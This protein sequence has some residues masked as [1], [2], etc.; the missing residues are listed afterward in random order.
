MKN[1]ISLFVNSLDWNKQII[2]H[3]K[4]LNQ[5]NFFYMLEEAGIRV[6]GNPNSPD[7]YVRFFKNFPHFKC[8]Y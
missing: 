1:F 5:K 3:T 8:Q 2:I 4:L 6:T 7:F